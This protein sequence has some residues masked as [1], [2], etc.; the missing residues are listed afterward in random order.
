M[1]YE[2]DDNYVL[3]VL[4]LLWG[5]CFCRNLLESV[6]ACAKLFESCVARDICGVAA[7]CPGGLAE[8]ARQCV[9]LFCFLQ[10]AFFCVLYTLHRSGVG[11]RRSSTI[12]HN[13]Q[14]NT[15]SLCYFH[16]NSTVCV[17]ESASVAA[18]NAVQLDFLFPVLPFSL[19]VSATSMLWVN[20]VASGTLKADTP[21]DADLQDAVFVYETVYYAELWCMNLAVVAVACSERSLLE[22]HYAALALTL[23]LVHVCA[24]SRVAVEYSAAEHVGATVVTLVF[25]AVLAPLWAMMVQVHTPVRSLACA[26]T[27][28]RPLTCARAAQGACPAALALAG[29]HAAIVLTLC[30]FHMLARGEASAGQVLL[31]RVGCTVAMSTAL[32]AVYAVG[33]NRQCE[34]RY[35]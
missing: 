24:Q 34:T 10:P 4:L 8:L 27:P 13:A 35:I 12:L 22:V 11:D 26:L 17:P 6:T 31:V 23:M 14:L 29:V 7:C 21:W 1:D 2:F 25:A 18:V 30:L 5:L 15:S 32:L 20:C 16:V 33:R 9:V 3:L 19:L 28:S